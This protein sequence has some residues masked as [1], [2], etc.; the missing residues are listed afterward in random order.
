MMKKLFLVIFTVLFCLVSNVGWTA[1]LVCKYTGFNCPEVGDIEELVE[2]DGLFFKKF[3][4][5]PFTG[6]VIGGEKQGSIKDGKKNG[7]WKEYYEDGQ[8]LKLKVNFKMGKRDGNWIEYH[9]NGKL[10]VK[11]NLKKGKRD[12]EFLINSD[13]GTIK[14]SVYQ[15]PARFGNKRLTESQLIHMIKTIIK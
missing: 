9:K 14:E 7:E 3:T 12:G 11:G 8:S 4:E 13:D 6:K 2:V 5:T 10:K 1:N 15:L